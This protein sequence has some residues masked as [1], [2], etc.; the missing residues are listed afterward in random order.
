[1]PRKSPEALKRVSVFLTS[2]Q[3]ERLEALYEQTKVPTAT[4]IREGVDLVL[5]KHGKKGGRR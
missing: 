4:R 1:M 5:S 3:V 2:R